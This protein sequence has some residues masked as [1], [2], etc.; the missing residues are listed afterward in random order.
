MSDAVFAAA[1]W[2]GRPSELRRQLV[3]QIKQRTGRRRDGGLRLAE[4]DSWLPGM[5]SPGLIPKPR[6][7][8]DEFLR[9]V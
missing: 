9:R 3:G 7:R 1:R 2:G 6:R 4:R 5:P 8:Q